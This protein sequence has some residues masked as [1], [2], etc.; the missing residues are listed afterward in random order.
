MNVFY[1]FANIAPV[2]PGTIFNCSAKHTNCEV[3]VVDGGSKDDTRRCAKRAGAKKVFGSKP[4]RSKQM[5]AGVGRATGDVLLFLHADC[6]LPPSWYDDIL[7]SV[8]HG[9]GWGC[10]ETIDIR[11][12]VGFLSAAL[13][14]HLVG[15]R[16]KLFK[17]P[18]GDQGLFMKKDYFASVDGYRD[19][20]SILED[21]DLVEKLSKKYGAP[22]IVP[23]ALKASGRRWRK[24]GLLQ[25][26]AINQL[27]L[28]GFALG[29][30]NKDL[31]HLYNM[32]KK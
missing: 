17:K 7:R 11:K 8:E 23:H 14:R 21:V 9:N 31:A 32:H 13:I 28:I 27:M 4:G 6:V 30:D 20:W 26:T 19:D 2:T 22:S 18:Y 10:F 24:L 29:I 15:S 1:V 16:T 12:D 3:I 5:N 25:T